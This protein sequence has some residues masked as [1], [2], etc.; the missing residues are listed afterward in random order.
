MERKMSDY[1][2][3]NTSILLSPAER[4]V[5]KMVKTVLFPQLDWMTTKLKSL[6]LIALH[7]SSSSSIRYLLFNYLFQ[8]VVLPYKNPRPHPTL[9][10]LWVENVYVDTSHL[11]EWSY[12]TTRMKTFF[13]EGTD[14]RLT[15]DANNFVVVRY[16]QLVTQDEYFHRLEHIG[17]LSF[18]GS[19]E[20][21]RPPGGYLPNL[22]SAR[23]E[24]S[25]GD[26][27]EVNI[28]LIIGRFC[29]HFYLYFSIYI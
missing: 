25:A 5:K 8:F 1:P 6:V 21:E 13:V 24:C 20:H 7:P 27:Y 18:V 19:G 16:F 2:N 17:P 23:I 12:F 29:I 9:E 11:F 15:N 10:R 22:R 26:G 3:G 28:I 14:T 4:E